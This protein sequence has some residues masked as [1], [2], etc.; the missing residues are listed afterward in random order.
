MACSHDEHTPWRNPTFTYFY[1]SIS[2]PPLLLLFSF[3]LHLLILFEY[4]Y[5]LQLSTHYQSIGRTLQ[6]WSRARPSLDC[7]GS[8]R[9]FPGADIILATMII[10]DQGICSWYNSQRTHDRC[11]TSLFFL[12]ILIFIFIEKNGWEF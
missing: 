2:S 6:K 10:V 5:S 1:P 12:V 8:S 3:S 7:L 11:S 9:S 4:L